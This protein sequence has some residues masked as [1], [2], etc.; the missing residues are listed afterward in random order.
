MLSLRA[1]V[2]FPLAAFCSTLALTAQVPSP[3]DFFGHVVG[4]DFKLINYS[5]MVRYFRAVEAASDRM[6]LVDIGQTSYGQRMVMAV[7]SS[8]KNLANIE[9][10]RKAS[11][12]ISASLARQLGLKL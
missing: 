10:L 2:M 11:V 8:P 4:A 3:T 12:K 9:Q 1:S 5:D 6:Q 7:I